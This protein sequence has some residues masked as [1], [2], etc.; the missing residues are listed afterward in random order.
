MGNLKTMKY[1]SD[2]IFFGM[3][4]IFILC[5]HIHTYIHTYIHIYIYIY[6][7]IYICI[8]HPICVCVAMIG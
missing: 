3:D 7:Y 8:A 4:D 5:I 2:V 6:I 1:F